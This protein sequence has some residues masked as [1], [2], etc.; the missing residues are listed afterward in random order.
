MT[1]K[2]GT[3][4]LRKLTK[5]VKKAIGLRFWSLATKEQEL[6]I[7]DIHEAT[8]GIAEYLILEDFNTKDQ[9]FEAINAFLSLEAK[10]FPYKAPLVYSPGKMKILASRIKLQHLLLEQEQSLMYAK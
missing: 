8:I 2:E 10:T 1:G 6:I 7:K 3:K 4:L 5:K 9:Y